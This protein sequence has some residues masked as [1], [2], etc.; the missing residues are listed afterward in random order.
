MEGQVIMAEFYKL[1]VFVPEHHTEDVKHAIFSAGGGQF[2]HYSHCAWQTLG[3]G[4]FKPEAN[5]SPFIGKQD[6]ISFVKEYKV[7][8]L[9]E[10]KT[11]KPSIEA[12][13]QAHPYE[14]PA[15]EVLKLVNIN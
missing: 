8:I 15:F 11:L 14:E 2:E 5:S 7:E 1:I 13:K 6:S 3:Q 12:L 4:Q 10:E 9:C